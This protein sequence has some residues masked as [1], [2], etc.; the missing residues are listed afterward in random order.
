MKKFFKWAGIVIVALI[1]IGAVS[2]GDS[3]SQSSSPSSQNSDQKQEAV[4]YK[5]NDVINTKEMEVTITNVEERV[6][7][8]NQYVNEKASEGG[9]LVAVIWKYKNI[10]DKPLSSYKAPS[11]KLVDVNGVEYDWDL[12][13]S[14]TYSIELDLDSKVLSD[15]NPGITVKD[16]KVFEVSKDS[17]AKSG[18]KLQVKAG[19]KTYLV[20]LD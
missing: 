8:G 1:V 5:V 10:S 18:W 14:S 6:K 7:V 19:G 4:T 11:T 15:L 2:G 9:T 16:A 12:G 20:E 13:K 3:D 17:Y